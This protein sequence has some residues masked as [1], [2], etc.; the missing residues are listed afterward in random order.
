MQGTWC[1]MQGARPATNGTDTLSRK[2]SA[3]DAN[4]EP[5]A[6]RSRSGSATPTAQ[7]AHTLGNRCGVLCDAAVCGFWFCLLHWLGA[8]DTVV[9]PAR[10]TRSVSRWDP[11]LSAF[12]GGRR[13]SMHAPRNATHSNATHSNAT[14]R[15]HAAAHHSMHATAR[16]SISHL[17][18][19]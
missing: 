1:F 13:N 6:T 19:P 16:N 10:A 4:L 7:C 15:M 9:M 8:A 17:I 18:S 12:F 11:P 14:H 5:R 2:R 3:Q